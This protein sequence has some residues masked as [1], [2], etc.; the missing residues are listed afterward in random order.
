[1]ADVGELAGLADDLCDLCHDVASCRPSWLILVNAP[2]LRYEDMV[3]TMVESG[4]IVRAVDL[5][6]SRLRALPT[7]HGARLRTP[8]RFVRHVQ[9]WLSTWFASDGTD[10]AARFEHASAQLRWLV[11]AGRQR[12]RDGSAEIVFGAIRRSR[13]RAPV[14]GAPL[15]RI[16]EVGIAMAAEFLRRSQRRDGSFRAFCLPPGASSSW[17]TA[18]VALVCER[19]PELAGACHDAA[20]YLE[21]IASSPGGLAYNA[22]V[23]DDVDTAAQALAVLA[24]HG[25]PPP[26]GAV[27]LVVD[28]QA[29]CGGFSTF[30]RSGPDGA[31]ASGWE[32]PHPEVSLIVVEALRRLDGYITERRRALGWITARAG[33]GVVAPYWWTSPAYSV[34][35]H[36]AAGVVTEGT[37]AVARSLLADGVGPPYTAMIIPG[38]WVDED[39]TWLGA[40]EGLLRC[41]NADGSW[42]CGP[43]LRV[44]DPGVHEASAESAGRAY[45]DGR[46]VFSTAHALAALDFARRATRA[47]RR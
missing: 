31:A 35:A 8:R 21:A 36:V 46:R 17:I 37:G 47:E 22:L 27:A 34:W 32:M 7:E 4:A 9:L 25:I 24:T 29:V 6:A 41:Q 19:V 16:I 26:S 14:A 39:P 13:P 2:S 12:M 33:R 10:V 20:R 44:T 28:A 5:M 15:T 18:H 23:R 30:P 38:A 40:V 11:R 3:S 43:C 42:D 1:M 45:A